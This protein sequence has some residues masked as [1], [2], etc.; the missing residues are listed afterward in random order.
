M[1]LPY[2]GRPMTELRFQAEP[3]PLQDADS[4]TDDTAGVHWYF[5]DNIPPNWP[6][7]RAYL[8]NVATLRNLVWG[9]AHVRPNTGL[10]ANSA[11]EDRIAD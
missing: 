2:A 6:E 11:P 4:V 5:D 9:Y 7:G 10:V 8:V 3:P 1:Y